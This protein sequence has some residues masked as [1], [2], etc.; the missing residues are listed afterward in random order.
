MANKI[1]NITRFDSQICFKKFTPFIFFKI[2]KPFSAKKR[3][4]KITAQTQKTTAHSKSTAT[5]SMVIFC[6]DL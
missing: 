1:Q 2:N 4:A 6:I 3:K 5:H